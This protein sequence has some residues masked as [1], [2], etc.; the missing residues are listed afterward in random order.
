MLFWGENWTRTNRLGASGIQTMWNAKQLEI[1]HSRQSKLG[2]TVAK[3]SWKSSLASRL[4]TLGVSWSWSRVA[5]LWAKGLTYFFFCDEV[6]K[7]YLSEII[8]VNW[9]PPKVLLHFAELPKT[10]CGGLWWE[11]F[12]NIDS[13]LAYATLLIVAKPA[14]FSKY[15]SLGIISSVEFGPKCR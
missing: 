6:Q 2:P 13:R 12:V 5:V 9:L 4:P 11:H 7:D 8:K 14:Q 3:W 1:L 10:T 15:P